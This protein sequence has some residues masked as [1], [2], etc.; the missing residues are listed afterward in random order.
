MKLFAAKQVLFKVD[1]DRVSGRYGQIS[2]IRMFEKIPH[3]FY[4]SRRKFSISSF[5][6]CLTNIIFI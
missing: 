4:D 6:W 3:S 2:I 1:W 5:W